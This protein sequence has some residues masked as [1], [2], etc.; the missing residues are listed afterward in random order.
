MVMVG[1]TIA[2]ARFAKTS[3]TQPRN[4]CS[5]LPVWRGRRLHNNIALSTTRTLRLFAV[6][7]TLMR[8]AKGTWDSVSSKT[9]KSPFSFHRSFPACYSAQNTKHPF[10]LSI[11]PNPSF[12][13]SISLFHRETLIGHSASMPALSFFHISQPSPVILPL[14]RT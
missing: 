11:Y 10:S 3:P 13:S 6:F 9:F 8:C 5:G 7:R 4:G 1:V 14:L 2:L 12:H